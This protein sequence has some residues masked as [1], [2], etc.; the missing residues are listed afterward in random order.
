MTTFVLP[1]IFLQQQYRQRQEKKKC[2]RVSLYV[3]TRANRKEKKKIVRETTINVDS[4]S[5]QKNT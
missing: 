1:D 4:T 2:V 5:N 3:V